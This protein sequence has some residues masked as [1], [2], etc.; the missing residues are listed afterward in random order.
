VPPEGESRVSHSPES[1]LE[2]GDADALKYSKM[3]LFGR[4]EGDMKTVRD[5]VRK[6]NKIHGFEACFKTKL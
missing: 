4:Y 3:R 5:Y 2:K 1:R 6:D